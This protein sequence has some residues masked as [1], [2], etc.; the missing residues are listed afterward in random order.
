MTNEVDIVDLQRRLQQQERLIR[1]LQEQQQHLEQSQDTIIHGYAIHTIYGW[2]LYLIEA[3]WDSITNLIIHFSQ[4]PKRR[5]TSQE[6]AA[7]I[8]HIRRKSKSAKNI[9]NRE[10]STEISIEQENARIYPQLV[11]NRAYAEPC[12]LISRKARV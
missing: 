4:K 11:G 10:G 5:E 3:L 1:Q 7:K 6:E 9:T 8:N 12:C 2:S